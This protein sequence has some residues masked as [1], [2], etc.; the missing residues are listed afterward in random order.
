MDYSCH[1]YMLCTWLDDLTCEHLYIYVHLI[2]MIASML[3]Y[4]YMFDYDPVNET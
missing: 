2:Y 3:M 4:V 1:T